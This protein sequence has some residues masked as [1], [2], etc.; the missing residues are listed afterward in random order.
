MISI[1]ASLNLCFNLF[2]PMIFS[3]FILPNI[4]L[5]LL[6]SFFI[7]SSLFLCLSLSL[8]LSLFSPLSFSLIFPSFYQCWQ[9]CLYG[10]IEDKNRT[11]WWRFSKVHTLFCFYFCYLVCHWLHLQYA[12]EFSFCFFNISI[13]ILCLID[14]SPLFVFWIFYHFLSISAYFHFS[15][16]LI[17]I[18]SNFG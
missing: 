5:P 8:S 11:L 3:R 9:I 18:L 7:L 14:F 10:G 16:F 2:L 1:P 4:Y 6:L 12:F 13:L 17:F 15:F